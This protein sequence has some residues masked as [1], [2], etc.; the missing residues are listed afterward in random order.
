[1]SSKNTSFQISEKKVV[2]AIL[3]DAWRRHKCTIKEKH[4]TKYKTTYD[5]LKN[6]PRDIP[7]SHFK[8]LIRYWNL[9]DIQRATKENKETPNQAEMFREIRQSKKGKPL[10]QETTKL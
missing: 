8:E 7:E 4:F 5:R 10:D 3:N 6:H 2:F 1:M 9:G